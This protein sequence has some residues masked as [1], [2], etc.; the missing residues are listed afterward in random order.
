MKFS[1]MFV[2]W[3]NEK[4]HVVTDHKSS[5]LNDFIPRSKA[6]IKYDDMHPFGQTLR[7]A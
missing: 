3:Q 4:P 6:H 1:L 5:G 2:V 7:Q